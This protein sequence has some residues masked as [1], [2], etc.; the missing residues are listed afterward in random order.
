MLSLAWTLTYT[1]ISAALIIS[2][3]IEGAV[4]IEMN[5]VGKDGELIAAAIHE[6]IENAVFTLGMPL[7]CY[8][9]THCLRTPWST[10]N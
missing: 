5:G 7:W 8:L 1:N 2:D 3:F 10:S 9:P 4:E 6:H